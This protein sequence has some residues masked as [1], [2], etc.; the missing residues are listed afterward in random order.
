MIYIRREKR[1]SKIH[2]LFIDKANSAIILSSQLDNLNNL[3]LSIVNKLFKIYVKPVKNWPNISLHE[4]DSDSQLLDVV[5]LLLYLINFIMDAYEYHYKSKWPMYDE[6]IRDQ[7][8]SMFFTKVGEWYNLVNNKISFLI[9]KYE[10]DVDDYIN[11]P[12]LREFDRSSLTFHKENFFKLYQPLYEIHVL[13]NKFE[14]HGVGE[15]YKK[16]IDYLFEI[17]IADIEIVYP[18]LYGYEYFDSMIIKD[19]KYLEKYVK[20]FRQDYEEYCKRNKH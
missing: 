1:N 19:D 7:L 3:L 11:P 18:E 17:N 13:E 20:R 8:Y 2:R 14:S 12:K 4:S 16:L 15:E 10:Q 5:Y 9:D 6:N